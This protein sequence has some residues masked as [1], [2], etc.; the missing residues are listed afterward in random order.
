MKKLFS[1]WADQLKLAF[2]TKFLDPATGVYLSGTQCAYVLPLAFGLVPDDCRQKVIDNLVNE[3]LVTHK[4]HLSVGLIGMQWLMQVLSD[5]GRPDVAWTIVTQTTRPSWGYMIGKGATTIW[6][7][8]D[9]DTRDPGM[10][11][12]A[13]LI[14]AGI[15]MPGSIRRSRASIMTG[16]SPA[17][18]TSSSSHS[19]P[20]IL[21]GSRRITTRPFWSHC[22]LLETRGRQTDN[23]GHHSA[24]HHGD[25]VCA[26]ETRGFSDGIRQASGRGQVR[27]IPADGK[28]RRRP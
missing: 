22:Q 2:N 11:S 25:S 15:L 20:V 27:E 12:E 4:G 16:A 19:H 17:S 5:I 18:S 14:Q 21:R 3:I 13:L 28:Q 10:N 9:C 26:G 8:W 23:G 24:E 6:E 7:R 1:E